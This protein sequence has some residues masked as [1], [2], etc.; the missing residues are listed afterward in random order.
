MSHF[1]LFF[2]AFNYF[3][4]TKFTTNYQRTLNLTTSFNWPL[5]GD[6]TIERCIWRCLFS[7][8]CYSL[9]VLSK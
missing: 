1:N 8:I 6:C 7:D 5:T 2:L 3:E 9:S 4:S